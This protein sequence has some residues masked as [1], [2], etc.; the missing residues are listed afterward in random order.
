[1]VFRRLPPS[2]L[3]PPPGSTP[4]RPTQPAKIDTVYECPRCQTRYLG[5]QR[6]DDCNTLVPAPGPGLALPPTAM[7]LLPSQTWSPT[8]NTSAAA[9]TSAKSRAARPRIG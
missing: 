5:E 9:N 2:R 1:M 6:C 8:T 3:A 7:I 4:R